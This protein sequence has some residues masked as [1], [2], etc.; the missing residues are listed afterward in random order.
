MLGPDLHPLPFQHPH[1]ALPSPPR[2]LQHLL[3][4]AGREVKKGVGCRKWRA[5]RAWGWCEKAVSKV[6]VAFISPEVGSRSSVC[7]PARSPG[8]P[9]QSPWQPLPCGVR[10]NSLP[11]VPRTG[12]VRLARTRDWPGSEKWTSLCFLASTSQAHGEKDSAPGF[13]WTWD[14]FMEEG[15]GRRI[16]L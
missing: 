7:L 13:C 9:L 15:G 16:C 12:G 1:L 11:P 14:L 4:G 8:Q 3:V 5:A 2:A 6:S 10:P